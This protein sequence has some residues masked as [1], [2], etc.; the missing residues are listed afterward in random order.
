MGVFL[1]RLQSQR[2]PVIYPVHLRLKV[3]CT[4][5]DKGLLWVNCGDLRLSGERQLYPSKLTSNALIISDYESG[6]HWRN[7][8]CSSWVWA[9]AERPETDLR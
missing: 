7:A 9:A 2:G 8:T 4:K 6:S 5:S 1:Q 3:L